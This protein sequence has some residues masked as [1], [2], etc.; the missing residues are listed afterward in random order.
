MAQP[1]SVATFGAAGAGRAALLMGL[2]AAATAGALALIDNLFPGAASEAKAESAASAPKRKLTT[3]MLT[4]AEGKYP[5]LGNDGV[6]YD[7]QYAGSNMKTGVYRKPHFGIFAEKQPEM[8]IDGKTT[9]RLVLNYPEIYSGILELS[10]TG[11]MGMRTYATGNVL[12]IGEGYDVQAHQAQQQ[13][14]RQEMRQTMAATAAAVAALTQRLDQPIHASV[15]YFGK[16]G[17]REAE[18]RGSRWAARNRVR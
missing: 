2:V 17:Q 1:D 4:Y 10:R 13:M 18:Q 5:V 8:I 16:G 14:Q 7:A 12:E 11:R 3:G 9:Q 15:N 6:V